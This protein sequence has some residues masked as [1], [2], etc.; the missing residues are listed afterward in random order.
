MADSL[1][2]EDGSAA[3]GGVFNLGVRTGEVTMNMLLQKSER[4]LA[5]L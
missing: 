4:G 3:C 2:W 5:G 1:T